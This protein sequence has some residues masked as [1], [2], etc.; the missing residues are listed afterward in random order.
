MKSTIP[1][2]AIIGGGFSGAAFAIHLARALEDREIA[3]DIYEPRPLLGAGL[4]YSSTDPAHRV[5]VAATRMAVFSEDPTHFDRWFRRTGEAADDPEALLQDGR[6]YPRRAVFGRYMDELL[7]R[8]VAKFPNVRFRHLRKMV[9][10]VR[11]SGSGYRLISEAG[12]ESFADLVVLSPGHPAP[13]LRWASAET[14][15]VPRFV[16]NP[17]RHGALAEIRPADKVLVIGTGLSMA[18]V[19]VSLRLT[20]HTD[21]ITAVS[22]RGLTPRP[23]TPLPVEAFGSFDHPATRSAAT[24]LRNVRR[25]VDIAARQ[26]KPWEGVI[27]N[28]RKQG[29]AIWQGLSTASRRRLLRH[30]RAWWDVHR[31][32]IAPQLDGVLVEDQRRGRLKIVKADVLKIEATGDAF[33]V[34]LHLRGKQEKPNVEQVFDSV[35]NCTGPDQGAVVQSNPLLHAMAA[36]GLLRAD[37]LGLGIEVDRFARTIGTDGHPSPRL[38]VAGPLARGYFG[39]LMSLPE[40]SQQPERLAGT[41]AALLAR[42]DLDVAV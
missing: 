25:A 16:A 1:R 29:T 3:L 36:G 12:D 13:T 37:A 26:G 4:A 20:G 40:V 21:P 41:I 10:D 2:I 31:Y 17:W 28:L 34:A 7:R 14:A 27:D 22:R 6:A 38:F 24:L 9:T 32:Q 35:V 30:A 15:A 42:D 5:N 33:R 8:M 39:E 11:P 23:R 18:D 19:V